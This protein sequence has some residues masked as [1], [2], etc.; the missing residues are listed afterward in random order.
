MF[1]PNCGNQLPDGSAFC[2]NCGAPVDPRSNP[3]QPQGNP[4][5][6]PQQPQENP[7]Q[8]PQQTPYGFAPQAPYGLAPIGMKW[9]KFLIYFLLFA[10]AI[11]NISDGVSI[12][13]GEHYTVDGVNVSE[14]VYE[15]YSGLQTIDVIYGVACIAFGAF[16]I[17]IR[18]QLAK[19]KTNAPVLF[20]YSYIVLAVIMAIYN[21]AVMGVVPSEVVSHGEL[22]GRAVGGFVG[23]GI[24][25][26]LNKIYFDKRKHLF[27]N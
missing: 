25:F 3:Q 14:A 5:Q 23:A 4:Y 16:Q 12:M 19:Y 21:F 9:F 24:M 7:Y 26:W 1:C 15:K 27:V 20:M 6:A 8:A 22:V 17:F 2:G 13:N 10:M 18:F 11:I